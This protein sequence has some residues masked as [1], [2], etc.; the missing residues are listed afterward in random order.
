MRSKTALLMSTTTAVAVGATTSLI[1]FN[2][3]IAAATTTAFQFQSSASA[4]RTLTSSIIR[5]PGAAAVNKKRISTK[6]WIWLRQCRRFHSHAIRYTNK[7]ED[8][9]VESRARNVGN[10][11]S[12]GSNGCNDT[13]AKML[14]CMHPVTVPDKEGTEKKSS[15]E[16]IQIIQ[17]ESYGKK[18]NLPFDTPT[19][20]W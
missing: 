20:E 11:G 1:T 3:L 8:Y 19:N 12:T 10:S 16:R 18:K 4:A 2:N 15:T 17:H 9:E 14:G 5:N 13:A 6:I 7:K